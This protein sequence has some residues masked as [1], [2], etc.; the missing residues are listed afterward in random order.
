[1]SDTLLRSGSL[2]R[3]VRRSRSFE[4]FFRRLVSRCG[5]M[6][7][8]CNIYRIRCAHSNQRLLH[9]TYVMK[10]SLQRRRLQSVT[11]V[12][13]AGA[14]L[15][16]RWSVTDRTVVAMKIALCD[17]YRPPT[18]V[19]KRAV[20]TIF[21][22]PSLS[23][24]QTICANG[25]WRLHCEERERRR[26]HASVFL[27]NGKDRIG[28]VYKKA[29]YKQFKDAK[30]A[31]EV[32]KPAWLGLLGPIIKAEVED[33][34]IIH[35]KNFASRSY[36]LHP[37]GVFYEK[38]SEGAF[39]PDGTSKSDKRD[40]AVPPGGNHTYKWIVKQEYAPTSEDPNC[41]TWIYHSHIDAPKDIAS[42]LIG[43]LLTCKKGTLDSS[44]N[45]LDVNKDF[46][47]MFYVIDENISWYLEENIQTFCSEPDTVEVDN[48]DFQ[49]SNKMHGECPRNV[50]TRL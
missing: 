27:E 29:I 13:D 38:D 36:T 25:T 18:A 37:H 30:Y 16:R 3:I 26:R 17:G 10:L 21:F 14:I 46:V 47:L 50:I 40:D 48:E 28:R 7:A 6:I 45:R 2:L 11:A 20:L 42:G 32:S 8:W 35:L 22:L 41:L 15:L 4:T 44:L 19:G 23:F 5:G 24:C 33:T 9:R 49:E 34:I 39:Y 43:A 1:M 12:Y 31:E